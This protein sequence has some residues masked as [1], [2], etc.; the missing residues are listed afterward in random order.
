MPRSGRVPYGFYGVLWDGD[1]D[2]APAEQ[3][4]AQW[5]LMA[6]SGVESVRTVFSWAA[7]RP[8]PD[9][10]RNFSGMD[11]KVELASRHGIALYPQ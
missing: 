5:A 7:A 3:Q 1:V 11:A 8:T 10:P 9:G 4:D 6:R 2:R